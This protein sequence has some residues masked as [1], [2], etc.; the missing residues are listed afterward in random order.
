MWIEGKVFKPAKGRH[1]AAEVPPLDVYTQGTS[2]K[3]AMFML[4]DAIELLADDLGIDLEIEVKPAKENRV[5]IGSSNVK[6]LIAFLLRRQRQ[7]NKLTVIEVTTR[8][9]ARSKTAYARYEQGKSEPSLSKLQTLLSAINPD[10]K[11]VIN[12]G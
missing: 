2:K 8:M 11:T 3:D 12:V 5:F 6:L 9:G 7:K 1:W 10:S 4:K